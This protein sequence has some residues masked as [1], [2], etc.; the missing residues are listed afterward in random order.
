M[1]KRIIKLYLKFVITM[2]FVI[3]LLI[4]VKHIANYG[5]TK[6]LYMK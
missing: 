3:G 2:Y 1:I 6:K 4:F 5:Y